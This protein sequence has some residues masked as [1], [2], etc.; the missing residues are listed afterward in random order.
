MSATTTSGR[1]GLHPERRRSRSVSGG[2]LLRAR[3]RPPG[4]D[5]HRGH[6]LQSGGAP[7][8]PLSRAGASAPPLPASPPARGLP[9]H[10]D[11]VAR[12]GRRGQDGAGG[13]CRG[14]ERGWDAGLR[15]GAVGGTGLVVARGLRCWRRPRLPLPRGA[16]EPHAPRGGPPSAAPR[17]FGRT[18]PPPGDVFRFVNGAEP[19]A[20]DPALLSGQSDGRIARALFEGLVVQDPRTLEPVPGVARAW[21]VSRRRPHV[22]L[23]PAARR[24]G[25]DGAPRHGGRLRVVVAAG[26]PPRH[27]EPLRRTSST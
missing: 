7:A 4:P 5:H 20:L 19:E 16:G 15:G 27:A 2:H 1:P 18:T 6:P 25:R 23:P 21:E 3:P 24:A 9:A 12:R 22:H 26:P 14:L 10:Q 17:F 11:L 13:R 8:A